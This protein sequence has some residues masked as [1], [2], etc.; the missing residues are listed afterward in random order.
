MIDNYCLRLIELQIMN[1]VQTVK[2]VSLFGA[3]ANDGDD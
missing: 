1:T 2:P 3:A